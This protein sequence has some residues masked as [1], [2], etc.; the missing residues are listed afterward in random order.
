M[1]LVEGLE[2]WVRFIAT[3]H[4]LIII[5]LERIRGAFRPKFMLIK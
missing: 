5:P 3:L 1:N 2:D 4:F